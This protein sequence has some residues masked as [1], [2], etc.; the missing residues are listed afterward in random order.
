MS[1][2]TAY[3]R[4]N[5][6]EF[7][8]EEISERVKKYFYNSKK[9]NTQKTYAR[10][11][12]IFEKW[13]IKNKREFMPAS[14]ATICEFVSYLA[15]DE[16]KQHNSIIVYVSS[17][18]LAHIYAGHDPSPTSANIVSQVMLGI[19][20]EHPYESPQKESLTIDELV[21]MINLCPDTL[22]GLRDKL[23]LTFQ[24]ACAMRI[25]EPL[26]LK[27]KNIKFNENGVDVNLLQ[28]KTGKRNIAMIDGERIKAVQLLKEWLE[29]TQ[30][31][32]GYLFRRFYKGGKLS[33]FP[34]ST[35]SGQQIWKKYAAMIGKNTNFI[36]GHTAR[37]TFSTEALE[38]GADFFQVM[39][40][41]G[42]KTT[43]MLKRYRR[44]KDKYTNH[45]GRKFL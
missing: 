26:S 39:D 25:S 18:R 10:L 12:L 14:S 29:K 2:L 31:N 23:L 16:E 1:N 24:V 15:Q 7:K 9:K 3:E 19:K 36:S 41:T 30:I 45:A 8:E 32:S 22:I 5:I 21:K 38:S 28:S 42:H 13:C 35:F 37:A 17:I 40:V 27:F 43:E 34:L 20:N 44:N 33:E 6:E 4:K 11:W